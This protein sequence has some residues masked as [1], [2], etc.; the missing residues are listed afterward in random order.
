MTPA[1]LCL[2]T[3][4]AHAQTNVNIGKKPKV[5]SQKA[6]AAPEGSTLYTQAEQTRYQSY[7]TLAYRA[8][9]RDS[10]ATATHYFR[11]AID[12]LPNHP[13]NAE[14]YYQLGQIALSED[15]PSL[16]AENFSHSLRIA[17]TLYKS[18]KRLG[19]AYLLR[20]DY[21]GAVKN[22]STYLSHSPQDTAT[23]FLRGYAHQ[24]LGN[25]SLALRDFQSVLTLNPLHP[26]ALMGRAV[27]LHR[28]GQSQQAMTDISS[29]I[30]RFPQNAT[31]YAVRAQMELTDNHLDAALIDASQAI[32]LAPNN[33]AHLLL[34]ADIYQRQ[35]NTALS[36]SDRQRAHL[37][38]E[39]ATGTTPK[40]D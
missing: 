20:A 18:R 27:I 13:S 23:I 6:D 40:P 26:D 35:G 7:V 29:L 16:A 3:P 22:Y 2:T 28:R 37:F 21:T 30:T 31:Y 14:V 25:D 5:E 11:E 19:D 39:K 1:I 12:L 34:R 10:L 9:L 8:L 24:Q 17:P 36:K 33:A 15:D 38:L 32:T 4:T